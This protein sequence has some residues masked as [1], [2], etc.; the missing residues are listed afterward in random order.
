MASSGQLVNM[1][2]QP[3]DFL[4]TSGGGGYTS[5]HNP[6]QKACRTAAGCPFRRGRPPPIG[7]A[8]TFPGRAPGTEGY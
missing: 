3:G 6:G 4:D 2:N 8:T 1:V 5:R 7:A